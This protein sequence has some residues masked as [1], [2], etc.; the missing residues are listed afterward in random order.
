MVNHS[1]SRP[2]GGSA[3]PAR[4]ATAVPLAAGAGPA[5]AGATV[6]LLEVKVPNTF[7]NSAE[8]SWGPAEASEK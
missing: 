4:A 3:L 2:G 7:E 5:A 1:K 6:R 8:E